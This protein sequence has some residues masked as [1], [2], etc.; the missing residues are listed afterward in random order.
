MGFA[1]F[2]AVLGAACCH[3]GWNALAKG[4]A[5]P[6]L[7]TTALSICA[8]IVAVPV[9]F[10][11][12]FPKAAAWPWILGSLST[13]F[14]Y[15]A[16]LIE[17]YRHGDLGQVYPI[18]RGS[19][20]LM[21]AGVST[22]LVGEQLTGLAWIGLLLLVLG[23]LLLALRGGREVA[24]FNLRGVG[25]ALGTGLTICAYTV[26]DGVGARISAAPLAYTAA[27]FVG[28]GL[29]MT[30]YALARGGPGVLS[31]SARVWPIGIA[32]GVMQFASYGIAIWAMTVAPLALV[33]ALRETSVLFGTLIGVAWLKEP[34][35]ALR[36]AA[37]AMVVAGLVLLRLA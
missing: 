24:R 18:A 3:A 23:V 22:F 32:G 31:A 29:V 6:F 8:G 33:A 16:G 27:L 28:S 15:F 10:V 1:V 12:G 4:R 11:T 17:A 26:V 37:G 35:H 30:I 20:P 36:V 13:H 25:Y 19:A 9:L 34:V 5:D 21:T 2:L 14:F 7:T